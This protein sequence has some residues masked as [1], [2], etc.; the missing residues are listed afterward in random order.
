MKWK[1][2]L[3]GLAVAVFFSLL[4]ATGAFGNL[5]YRVYDFFLRFRINRER[6]SNVVFLNVDDNAIAYHGVFPWPRS[7]TADGILRLKEYG[8]GALIFDI[9]FI[10]RGHQGVDTI[11]LSRGLPADFGRSFSEIN[12]AAM[13]VFNAVGTAGWAA[14][15]LKNTPRPSPALSTMNGTGS[16]QGLSV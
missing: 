7:V 13:D 4:Y 8:L 14:A 12:S 15:M 11:Y 1:T 5:G 16:L 2:V 9:E 3:I 6:D 10:D